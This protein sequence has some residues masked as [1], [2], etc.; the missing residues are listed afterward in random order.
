MIELIFSRDDLKTVNCAYYYTGN[1]K[2]IMQFKGIN[3]KNALLL[4]NP[5][6][7]NLNK[8]NIFILLVNKQ[9]KIVLYKDLLSNDNDLDTYIFNIGDGISVS[10]KK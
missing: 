4:M 10:I 2:L 1:N 6:E 5:F 7:E 9:D 8:K 3:E